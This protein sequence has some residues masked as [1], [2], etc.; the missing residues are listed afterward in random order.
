MFIFF[1]N[2]KYIP[3]T[4][5]LISIDSE[6]ADRNE[7]SQ[8]EKVPSWHSSPISAFL[9]GAQGRV[10]TLSAQTD[11]HVE[12]RE[13]AER[14][15]VTWQQRTLGGHSR[16]YGKSLLSTQKTACWKEDR[17]LR[18]LLVG[19]EPEKALVALGFWS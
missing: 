14:G 18:G 10:T 19:H 11:E 5:V 6:E 9:R 17:D 3:R 16:S 12:S 7:G 2:N 4:R 13:G 1:K 8:G 15:I